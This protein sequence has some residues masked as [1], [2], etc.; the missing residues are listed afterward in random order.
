[1]TK[2]FYNYVFDSALIF[3]SMAWMNWFHPAEISLQLRGEGS[4]RNGFDLLTNRRCE[5]H[6]LN[7]EQVEL[8]S[9]M[10]PKGT[11]GGH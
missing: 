6:T 10:P 3:V 7:T 8:N 5:W 2:E 11:P 9:S 4:I 1:M